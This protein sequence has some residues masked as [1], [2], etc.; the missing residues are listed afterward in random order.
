MIK[1][2][3]L[4]LLLI[5]AAFAAGGFYVANASNPF[6]KAS[7]ETSRLRNGDLIFQDSQ[8]SQCLAIQL[9]TKSKYSHCGIIFQHKDKWFV[10]EAVGPVKATPLNNWIA[11]GRDKHYVVKR[12]KNADEVLTAETVAKMMDIGMGFQ[13]LPYDLTFEWSDD[14]IYC[15]ELIWKIY[16]QGADV[17][18][19]KLQKLEEFDL[20][21]P[22]VKQ[23]IKERYGDNIPLDEIAV[24]PGAI[25]DCDLLETVE[26]N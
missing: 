5:I 19:G 6:K 20:S 17:E 21:H 14:K 26:S 9:A 18:I 12:L 24:S 4:I 1:K 7:A 10:Y 13:G 25:F 22:V 23:K 15:S 16:K 2:K 3:Y 8:S 11:R